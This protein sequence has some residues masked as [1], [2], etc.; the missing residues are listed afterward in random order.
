MGICAEGSQDIA[1]GTGGA[2]CTDCTSSGLTC[3]F[4]QCGGGFN[5]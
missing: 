4:Q 3:L 1:C 2:A 5:H